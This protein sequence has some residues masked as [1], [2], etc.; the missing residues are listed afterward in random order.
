MKNEPKFN[1][2]I[3]DFANF[4]DTIGEIHEKNYKI[5]IDSQ[6]NTVSHVGIL[7]YVQASE[8]V[9]ENNDP[10]Q[11]LLPNLRFIT[12]DKRGI[13][14][15]NVVYCG[16]S[17]IVRDKEDILLRATI[18]ITSRVSINDDDTITYKSHKLEV[19]K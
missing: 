16:F 4:S 12:T 8:R 3:I 18:N 6:D 10:R 11:I 5:L 7:Q 19:Y 14:F 9:F 15:N 2:N 1:M 17:E 13:S